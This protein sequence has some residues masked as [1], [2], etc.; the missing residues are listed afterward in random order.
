MSNIDKVDYDSLVK[1]HG[2]ELQK[3]V[4]KIHALDKE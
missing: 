1:T 3:C 4:A 2:A